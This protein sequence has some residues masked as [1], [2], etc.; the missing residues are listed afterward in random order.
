MGLA[1]S[2]CTAAGWDRPASPLAHACPR[3]PQAAWA[4]APNALQSTQGSCRDPLREL[5]P[6][7]Q[8]LEHGRG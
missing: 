8:A 4:A 6:A 5:P 3:T 2:P 1:A 7:G